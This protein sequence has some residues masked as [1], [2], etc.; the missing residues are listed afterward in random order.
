MIQVKTGPLNINPNH[1]TYLIQT[2]DGL[3]TLD[4]AVE[5]YNMLQYVKWQN[6]NQWLHN[7]VL[8][9]LSDLE[10]I[11]FAKGFADSIIPVGTLEFVKKFVNIV[12]KD[13]NKEPI[14]LP[15]MH[16]P[17]CLHQFCERKI[18]TFQLPNE[19]LR[20]QEFLSALPGKEVFVK[21]GDIKNP[22]NGRMTKELL[23]TQI[24]DSVRECIKQ[25]VE[26]SEAIPS[27]DI[28]SEYRCFIKNQEL[29][30]VSNYAGDFKVTPDFSV[31]QQMIDALVQTSA[32]EPKIAYTL[33]VAILRSGKTVPIEMHEFYSCG[34]YGFSDY[35]LL[36]LMTHQTWR[37]V[38]TKLMSI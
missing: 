8:C 19:Y 14:Q 33:D 4:F 25:E 26:L 1:P 16:L 22:F 32:I 11:Q 38:Y 6:T 34:L 9:E 12:R 36:R 35:R 23:L 21:F 2:C 30:H 28:L 10:T 29:V 7:I 27:N 17:A 37:H 20:I 31:I 18:G 13:R 5:T 24:K 3:L 15:A